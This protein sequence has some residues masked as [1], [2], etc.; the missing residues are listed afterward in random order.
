MNGA[1][2]LTASVGGKREYN[3]VWDVG[4]LEVGLFCVFFVNSIKILGSLSNIYTPPC[5][6]LF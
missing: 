1:D 3:S 6:V 5:W 4:S 2:L